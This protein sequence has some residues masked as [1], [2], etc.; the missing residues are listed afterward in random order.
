MGAKCLIVEGQEGLVGALA[1]FD[2]GLAAESAAP[3]VAAGRGIARLAGLRILPP[4]GKD[5]VPASEQAAK[6]SDLGHI[7]RRDGDCGGRVGPRGRGR[8]RHLLA[9]QRVQQLRD[10]GTLAIERLEPSFQIGDLAAEIRL[11]IHHRAFVRKRGDQGRF[12]R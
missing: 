11:G 8:L 5:I 2:L 4:P 9:L 1:A 10:L 6:E 7:R 3:L 12:G